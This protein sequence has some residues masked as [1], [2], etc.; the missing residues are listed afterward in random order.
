MPRLLPFADAASTDLP[1]P[2]LLRL[3]LFQVSVGVA[4]ALLV[5]T[6]NRVMIV[7]LHVAAW[8][9]SL[10]VALPI[11]AAPFRAFVGWRSDHHASAIGWRRVPYIWIGTMLQFGGL[12]IMPFALLV[13]TGQGQLGLAWVGHLAAG[14][15]FLLV[16][17]GLQTTQTT[18]LALATDLAPES[19]RPRVVALMYVML[20]LGM[21][22]GGSLCGALLA[23]FS[24]QRLVQVVQG[25]ALLSVFL[26]LVAV[27]KQEARDPNRRRSKAE[28]APAFAPMWRSFIAQR[29]ARR[30]LWTVALGTAAFNMQDIVLEPYGGEILHLGVGATSA[31]TAL[32]AA[33]ALVAFAL[34]ARWLGRGADPMRVAAMGAVAGLPAFSAVI[35]S[36]PLDAA[37]LFRAGALLIGFGGGLF[38]VGTL[39]AAMAMERREHVGLALGAWGAVQASAAGIAVAAGGAVRDLVSGLATQGRLGEAL[40]DPVTGYSFVYHVEMVLLFAAIVAI[41]PLVRPL[42]HGRSAPS[43][44]A[45]GL[46][47]FPG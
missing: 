18:G 21:V 31:L 28:A 24:E 22:G 47:D 35:F 41:G 3:A 11:V 19:T 15:A 45:F 33:G 38:A 26:N 5:G 32:L 34:A 36:A 40:V 8:L 1:L 25:A 43:R 42:G 10:M 17:A 27:W 39:T 29:H 46:A 20:L 23:D 44:A 4:A 2:R 12:A 13:L 14:L 30:F 6:L 37:W 7:E 16:G 9:V